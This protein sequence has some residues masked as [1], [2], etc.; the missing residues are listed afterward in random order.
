MPTQKTR[1]TYNLARVMLTVGGYEIGGYE[2]DAITIEFSA[3][4]GEMSVSADGEYTFS[5]I[6][7]PGAAVT[8]R[9]RETSRGYRELATLMQ[10]QESTT[11]T[12]PLADLDFRLNDLNS[13]D[14]VSDGQAVFTKRPSL[15]KAKG[16]GT[17]EF[18][19][20]L[21]NAAHNAFFGALIA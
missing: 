7:D 14:K 6:N 3:D 19:M 4:I 5:V 13:G 11:R 9:L 12:G 17:R 2:D 1:R 8:I 18:G 15:S 10:A 20:F 21:P 16:A